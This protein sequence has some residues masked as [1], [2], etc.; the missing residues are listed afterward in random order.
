MSPYLSHLTEEELNELISRYYNKEKISTLLKEYNIQLNP[1]QLLKHLPPE[2]LDEKCRYCDLNLEKPRS[3]RERY[4][5]RLAEAVCPSCS[6]E[7]SE[8]C[9]CKNCVELAARRKEE[10]RREKQ[11]FMNQA[12]FI[13]EEAKIDLD[14]LTFTEKVYLGALL[15]E[16]ITED[17]TFIKPVEEFI[18]PLAPTYEFQLEILKTLSDKCAIVIHSDS[19][20]E[21]IVIDDAETGSYRYYPL[22]VKWALNVKKEGLTKVPL[23]ESVIA[24]SEID[25]DDLDD[26]ILLWK[27][28]ALYESL[29]YLVYSMKSI[30]RVDFSIGEKTISVFKNLIND[31]SV[32]QVYSIVYREINNALRIQVEKGITRKHAANTVIGNS[33]NFGDRAKV[34][35]WDL[36]K[37]MRNKECPESALSKFFYNSIIKIGYSGFNEVPRIEVITS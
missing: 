14:S 33:Q 28:I 27:K 37:Y 32:S 7:E 4:S 36:Q 34:N 26:S 12:F 29:E 17:Y 11:E 31:Y 30:L 13:D 3:S 25:N 22:K 10:E 16:G 35:K 2:I 1:G 19:D 24:P 21:S 20:L 15:R 18:N 23:V 9:Y 5:W 8:F 6:H